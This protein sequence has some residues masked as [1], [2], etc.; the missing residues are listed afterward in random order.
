MNAEHARTYDRDV[1]SVLLEALGDVRADEAGTAADADLGAL[2]GGQG[3]GFVV[4]HFLCVKI[5]LFPFVM[6][7][8]RFSDEWRKREERNNDLREDQI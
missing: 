7:R 1:V 6:R 2:S 3:E 4:R 5:W 8:L